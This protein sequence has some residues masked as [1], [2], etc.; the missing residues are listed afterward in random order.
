LNP[1]LTLCSTTFV[2]LVLD[3]LLE[4]SVLIVMS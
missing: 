1:H 2:T 3:R 4:L